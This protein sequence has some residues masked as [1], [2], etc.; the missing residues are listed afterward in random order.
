M[1]AAHQTHRVDA[2]GNRTGITH[3]SGA[4]SHYR[5]ND[6]NQ[7]TEVEH[8]KADGSLCPIQLHAE[9]PTAASRPSPKSSPAA[10]ARSPTSTTRRANCWKNRWTKLATSGSP[11]TATTPSA[12]A[13]ASR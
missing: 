12:T 7:L 6:A 5:Y 1:Q 8:L 13:S 11:A 10:S 4:Q 9:M 2:I 3:A